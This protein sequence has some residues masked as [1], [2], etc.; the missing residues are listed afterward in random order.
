MSENQLSLFATG[1]G[2]PSVPTDVR[3]PRKRRAVHPPL[4]KTSRPETAEICSGG[5]GE[6]VKRKVV[7]LY[8]G[9]GGLDLGL[10]AAGFTSAVAVEF[11]PIPV[12][13]LLDPRNRE[14]WGVVLHRSIHDLIEEGPEGRKVAAP[15][16]RE[17]KLKPEEASL[18]A[19]GPPCQPFSKSGYW[20]SGDAKRLDDPRAAT[21]EAYL[22]VLET[23]RPE[24][25]LLE[26]VPG[27]AFDAKDEGLQ[28]L[29]RRVDEINKRSG[30]RYSFHAAQ[31]NA[32]RYGVPQMRERVFIVGH[33]D[34]KAFTFPTPTH[35]LPPA[36]DLTGDGE[37][38]TVADEGLFPFATAWDAIGHL[39]DDDDPTLAP[40]GKW[41][42][43]LA[44]IPEGRNYL[45]HTPRNSKGLPIWGWRTRFYNMLLKL[46][47]ARPS[48]TLTAQPGPAIGPF[49]WRNRRLSAAELVGLQT[50]PR[51]YHIVGGVLEAH[52][53]LGNAVPSAMSEMLGREIRR[54]LLGETRV[55][56]G[57]L[58]LVPVTRGTPP[59]PETPLPKEQLPEWVLDLAD[60]G[61]AEH[62]GT[63]KGPGATAR[64][65]RL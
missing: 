52:K 53:Q 46:A 8:T 12:R 11:D 4:P 40:K 55:P 56:S 30:T 10:H 60:E 62:P 49:H 51:D 18:L 15:L 47:K 6:G 27:L 58:S 65:A 5:T 25:F 29:R 33:R 48:W 59:E 54:Q 35:A 63:G 21:L 7:S 61:K 50:F 34:G 28:Y 16:L 32:A 24:A 19:G 23:V 43:V 45:W 26:N 41:A 64:E 1:D 57:P 2:R 44:S 20:H 14:R 37:P 13:T 39:Q 36:V 9:A 17:A 22:T 38:P 31:L 3:H 42:P